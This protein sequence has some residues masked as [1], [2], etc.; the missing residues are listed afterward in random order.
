M[1]HDRDDWGSL[2]PD[3]SGRDRE[4]LNGSILLSIGDLMSGLLLVFAL[5]F[6]TVMAQLRSYQDALD[7]LPLLVLNTLNE[8]LPSGDRPGSD[9]SAIA[10]DPATGDI[11]I[12]D[13]ILFSSGSAEL[14][15]SGRQFLDEFVPI[16]SDLAFSNPAIAPRLARI[17]IEG[18]TSRSGN[19]RAN[20]DLSLRRARAV[21]DRIATA[22]PFP[23]QDRFVGTLLTA[24]RGELDANPNRDDP[25]DRK[26]VF[27]FQFQR[28][29][30]TD[31]FS[32][33]DRPRA[34]P[35]DQP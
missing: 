25:R 14:S 19:D 33:R 24:G 15:P 2:D 35:G 3:H 22:P 17:V 6:V 4:P 13:R 23:H 31:A 8:G 1:T 7:R 27:R 34:Q 10:I 9:T 16:Y 11:S 26:V 12:R 29:D 28:T 30:F 5:L 18:H 32:P 20:L 21:A